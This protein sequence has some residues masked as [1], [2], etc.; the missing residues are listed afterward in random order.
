MFG[1]IINVFGIE[2]EE[3]CGELVDGMLLFERI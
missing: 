1:M 3:Q 2:I